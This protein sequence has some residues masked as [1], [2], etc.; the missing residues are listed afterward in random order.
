MAHYDRAQ[1]PRAVCAA[2]LKATYDL[3]PAYAVQASTSSAEK[4]EV[5]RARQERIDQWRKTGGAG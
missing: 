2:M 1:L 3:P 4:E 5:I